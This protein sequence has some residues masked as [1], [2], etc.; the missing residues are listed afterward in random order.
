[1]TLGALAASKLSAANGMKGVDGITAA[2]AQAP[3]AGTNLGF[4]A[5]SLGGE[6]LNDPANALK[7]MASY[8]YCQTELA[9]YSYDDKAG[10]GQFAGWG[11]G[12]KATSAADFKKMADD[13]GIKILSS[14]M[15]PNLER[16]A[17]YDKSTETK[18]LDFWKKIIPDHKMFGVEYI[19]QPSLPPIASLEDAQ[20]VAEVFNKVG[21]LMKENGI[22]WGYHNHNREFNKVKGEGSPDRFI[23]EIFITETDPSLVAIELDVYWT[24]MG[25]QDP[26]EWI[27]KYKDRIQLLHIKDRLVLGQSGM[28]NFEQI[29]KNFNAN[30]HNT[31]FV[32]IEDTRSGKQMQRMEESANYL[33]AAD[34]VK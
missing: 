6:L 32:E 12:G 20:A 17:K 22:K 14:H 16:G 29:F 28:M 33:L 3:K 15:T 7:K 2:T 30:G 8:G 1:M 10:H 34:F 19:V 11:G 13:A 21:E 25:Q 23:E 5:Y 9:F 4:Q 24:V 27:N 31:F 18:I 26:V